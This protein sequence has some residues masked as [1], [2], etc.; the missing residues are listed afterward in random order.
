[1]KT[2]VE[3]RLWGDRDPLYGVATWP[4][5]E[6][7]GKHPW[8]DSEFYALGDDWLDFAEHW[9]RYGLSK[10]QVMEIGCGAGRIT[11]RLAAETL[12]FVTAC[13][14]SEGMLRY[15]KGRVTSQ[16]I[17]WKLSDGVSLPVEASSMDGVFSRHVLQHM[18]SNAAQL[19]CFREIHRV[20]RPGGTF[21]IHMML[22][23]FP[24]ANR[25]FSQLARTMYSGFLVLT[26]I[27]AIIK[28]AAMKM[29]ASPYMHGVSYETGQLRVGLEKIGLARIE[30]AI[31]PV[32][33]N[34]E[35]HACVFGTRPEVASLV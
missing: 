5:R 22:H 8:T 32:R 13:D 30:F 1:M 28:R 2:N 27:K 14:V 26:D 10:G 4:G 3:W 24:Q 7:D 31:F 21:M 35:L 11:N 12:T 20:L 23:S 16:N 15:A 18:S 29:G 25:S 17:E 33:T 9:Q 6:K 34:N 19:D